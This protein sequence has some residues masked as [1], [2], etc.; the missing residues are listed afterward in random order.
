MKQI[1]DVVK[2]VLNNTVIQ[3]NMGANSFII[4]LYL[5]KVINM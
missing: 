5:S 2:H 4:I 1:L 3:N